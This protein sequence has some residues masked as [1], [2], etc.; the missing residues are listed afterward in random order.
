LKGDR[1]VILR[2]VAKELG[3]VEEIY[4]HP[5]KAMQYSSGIQKL[6]SKTTTKE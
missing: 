1:K 2:S 4:L 5:K 6:L 3:L